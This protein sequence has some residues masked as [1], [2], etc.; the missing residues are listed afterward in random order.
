VLLGL[1]M[2]AVAARERELSAQLWSALADVPGLRR[3]TLWPEEADRVGVATFTF[4]GYRHPLLAAILSAEYAIGVRHGCFCAHPLM[5][6]LLGVPAV[7][8]ERLEAELRAGRRP[9]LPGAVRASL[10]LGTTSEDIDQLAGAL[11]EIAVIGPRSR[12]EYDPDL[13]EYRPEPEP[14]APPEVAPW[15][16]LAAIDLRDCRREALEDPDTL[17]AFVAAVIEAIGMRAHGPLRLERFGSGELEG[18]SAMQFIETS[19]ITVHAD[20][21]SGRCFA[22]VFSCRSFDPERAAAVAV[23]HFG[24]RSRV[25]VLQR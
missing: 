18:W 24:G 6:R 10:G 4:D 8:L 15:G 20:E 7:E 23:E 5:A 19:S 16:M 22:D 9:A 17:R 11:H 2:D 25:R 21:V 13:D 3:L 1:G 14:P 12:Y